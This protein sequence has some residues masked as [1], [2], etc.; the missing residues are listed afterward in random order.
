[1]DEN[2]GLW[3]LYFTEKKP[4]LREKLVLQ[5]AH[6]IKYCAIKI[7]GGLPKNIEL[8]DLLSYGSLGLLDAID[9]FDP[10]HNT[11]FEYYAKLRIRGSI[12]DGLRKMD[13]APQS[14][15]RKAKE[16]ERAYSA[17]E[18]SLNRYPVE[19][20]V[21]NYLGISEKDLEKQLQEVS[22]LSILALDQPLDGNDNELLSL[23]D[24]IE[25]KT[26]P[27]PSAKMEFTELKQEL[28]KAISDLTEKER[29]VVTLLYFEELT[30]K[31]ISKVLDL[32]EGRISQIHKKAVL[33][34]KSRLSRS[35]EG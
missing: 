32:S 27:N 9:R 14:L 23:V 15:R 35:W 26:S 6:L 22:H 11:N 33:K 13:W 4:E 12:I 7:H 1:M 2:K 3:T 8:D 10:K 20:E 24:L 16:I 30:S 18:Q 34:L 5:Y 17:L 19:E 21:A 31:E 25:D 29:L 28:A